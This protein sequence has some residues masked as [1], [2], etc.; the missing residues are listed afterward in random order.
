[1]LCAVVGSVSIAA[2]AFMVVVATTTAYPMHMKKMTNQDLVKAIM[3]LWN[4][5]MGKNQHAETMHG[6]LE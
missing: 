6:S 1:M 5:E 2:F 3:Y 4:E